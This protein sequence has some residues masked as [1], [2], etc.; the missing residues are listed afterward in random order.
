MND[1]LRK[2]A[3]ATC[4]RTGLGISSKTILAYCTDAE[5]FYTDRP[6]DAGDVSRCINLL[7]FFPEWKEKIKHISDR[8]PCWGSIGKNWEAIE[9]AYNTKG[10]N[11]VNNLLS[12][13]AK[14]KD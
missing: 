4:N 3:T 6:Y 1:D 2:L 8:F 5:C 7:S 14:D 10:Y 11:A 13:Y 12:L 9:K